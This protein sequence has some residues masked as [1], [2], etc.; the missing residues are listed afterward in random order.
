[1]WHSNW[2]YCS[3]HCHLQIG[4]IKDNARCISSK[5]KRN[6]HYHNHPS[7]F[8]TESYHCMG[9][10]LHQD[11]LPDIRCV[12]TKRPWQRFEST[13][14]TVPAAPAISFFPTPVDP[15]NVIFRTCAQDHSSG[16][17]KT[18]KK[19]R[20]KNLNQLADSW[21]L[22]SVHSCTSVLAIIAA[23]ISTAS[24]ITMFN[25]PCQMHRALQYADTI[26]TDQENLSIT[27]PCW[28]TIL[29]EVYKKGNCG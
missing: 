13:F 19:P 15:V 29:V 9:H 24:P 7:Q 18:E 20:K 17:K 5:F 12:P 27:I 25:T 6:L 16:K 8:A 10:F 2:T 3:F 1:M 14:L 28:S 11:T 21:D 22:I 23:P 4:I 26:E